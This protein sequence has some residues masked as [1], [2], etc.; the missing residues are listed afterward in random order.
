L[1][2]VTN[3]ITEALNDG[4]FCIGIFLD[5]KKAFDVCSH[6]ILLKKL[7]KSFGIRG[8]ALLWFKNYLSGR[9][10]VVDINGS[11]SNPRDI[12]ISVLQG[13]ILGPILFLCYINDLPNATDLDTFLFADDTSGLKSGKN[14]NEL[15]EHCN[16]ELQKMA[17][18]FRANKMCVN[19]SKTKYIIFH[20]KGKKVEPGVNLVFNN[21]EI[22]KDLDPSLITPLD[23]ICN[24]N[25]K[26]S[27]RSY[28]LL[29]VLLDE[30]LSFDA[31]V[32][33]ICNKLS[34]SL[35]Y[36]NRAKNF[37]DSQSLKMLYYSLV[38]SNLLYCIGTTS[39]MNQT[40]FKKI[41]ILQKKAIRIVAGANYK[42]NTAPLFYD[43]KILPYDKLLKL[44]I[45]KFMH[46][47]EYNHNHESFSIYWPLNNQ[48]LLDYELRNNN[49]R[50]VKRINFSQ[51]KNC[52]LFTF[53]KIWNELSVNLRL[54]INPVTFHLE[55]VNSLFE[56]VINET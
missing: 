19:T 47:I 3:R 44:F 41:K 32:R 27:E 38:H 15:I 39:A 23:K 13:S 4:K 42:A 45:C 49:M 48:R 43:L 54:H 52:P 35:F 50:N 1:L 53:P 55:L 24:S 34:K 37:V 51:L 36:L 17:N 16:T 2:H 33:H 12:N 11:I 10:Q 40:N 9:S 8:T 14:L 6:D 18:W 28:K 26:P 5:L 25:E 30:H 46:A 20:T 21:N 29:G 7:E 31:H 22:G 56:E